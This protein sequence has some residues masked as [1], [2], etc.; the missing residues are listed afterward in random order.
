MYQL[1]INRQ[2]NII[3]NVIQYRMGNT[4]HEKLFK[5]NI[6]CKSIIPNC[7]TYSIQLEHVPSEVLINPMAFIYN[8]EEFKIRPFI[9]FDIVNKEEV[10]RKEN[11]ITYLIIEKDIYFRVYYLDPD[12]FK[13]DDLFEY[14]KL[15]DRYGFLTKL[16]NKLYL[17]NDGYAEFSAKS[18]FPGVCKLRAKDNNYLCNFYPLKI[19]FKDD[20]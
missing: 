14:V 2:Y 11:N 8:N 13:Y 20:L 16:P 10:L 15:K 3:E 7:E 17:N 19:Q 1:V 12:N 9:I 18:R 6:S 5:F 4:E